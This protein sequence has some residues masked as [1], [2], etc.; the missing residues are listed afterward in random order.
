MLRIMSEDEEDVN[1]NPK[2]FLRNFGE[3]R[4]GYVLEM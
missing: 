1:V 2:W 3:K 4:Q